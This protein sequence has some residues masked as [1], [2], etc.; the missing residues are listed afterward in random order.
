[1]AKIDFES[2]FALR[3]PLYPKVEKL[4]L[5]SPTMTDPF[6]E[7]IHLVTDFKGVDSLF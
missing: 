3:K 7:K 6:D 5:M 2:A 4:F 1:M